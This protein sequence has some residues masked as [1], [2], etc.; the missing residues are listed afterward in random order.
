MRGIKLALTAA[1][2]AAAVA[3]SK[4]PDADGRP[5]ARRHCRYRAV[6]VDD[7]IIYRI[8]NAASSDDRR[9]RAIFGTLTSRRG[10]EREEPSLSLY[11]NGNLF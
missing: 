2:A 4:D 11:R 10:E 3:E 5:D 6:A 9:A 1:A 7:N 8:L